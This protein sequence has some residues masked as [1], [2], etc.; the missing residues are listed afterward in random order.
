MCLNKQTTCSSAGIVQQPTR[1]KKVANANLGV[2]FN[3][4]NLKVNWLARRRR[5]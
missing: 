5:R 4:A 2:D 3:I 1:R